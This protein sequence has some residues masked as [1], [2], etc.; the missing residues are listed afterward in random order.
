MAKQ[1]VIA[2]PECKRLV[3]AKDYT[4]HPLGSI[5]PTIVCPCGYKGIPIQITLKEYMEWSNGKSVEELE[6]IKEE[7]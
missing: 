2:C 6:K 5:L 3:E 4:R 1:D 7:N